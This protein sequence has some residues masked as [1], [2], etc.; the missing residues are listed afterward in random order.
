MP[1]LTEEHKKHI[2]L[3]FARYTR[4]ADIMRSLKD[5][6]G[7]IVPQDQLTRYNP[8]RASYNVGPKWK[9]VWDAEREAY[10]TDADRVPISK[11]AYRIAVLQETL[12]E[13]KKIHNHKLVLEILRAAGEEMGGLLTNER[14]VVGQIDH[15]H[16][17]SIEDMRTELALKMATMT[18]APVLDQ[19]TK[20]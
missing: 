14:K 20:H 4:P 6:F 12:K 19:K 13:A 1:I 17:A 3:S 15:R 8:E 16:E 10:L 18:A 7:I 2:V 11:Q 9:A 5:D